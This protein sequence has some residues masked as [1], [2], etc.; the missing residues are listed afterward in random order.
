MPYSSDNG[1]TLVDRA[2]IRFAKQIETAFF[3]YHRVLDLGAGSGTY[4]KRYANSWLPRSKFEWVG[5]EIWKPYI[6]KFSLPLLYDKLIEGDVRE[7]VKQNN[8]LFD[9]CF[10]GDLVEHM[11]KEEGV[12]LVRA[13]TNIAQ[14]VIVSI[15]IVHY[16][17]DA[18]EGNPYEK[19]VKDDWSVEE[20]LSSLPNIVFHGKEGEIG[21]FV[22][23]KDFPAIKSP[24]NISSWQSGLIE[25]VLKPQIGV[26]AI[27]K[28]EKHFL[29]EFYHSIDD[30][31]FIS[32]CD[33]GSTDGTYEELIDLVGHRTR[34]FGHEEE[35]KTYPNLSTDGSMFVTKIHVNPWRFDDARN[36]ALS[37]LPEEIDVCISI[38]LDERL[39][40]GWK[41]QLDEIVA[42]HLRENGRPCDRYNHRF[43][44]IWNWD[45]P[46]EPPSETEHW[47]ERIHSRKGYKWSLPVHE[48]LVNENAKTVEWLPNW[49]MIQKPDTTKSRSSY[50][51]LLEQSVKE[52]PNIWKSWS[53]LAGEYLS[54][55]R[56]DDAIAAIRKAR[57]LP[58]SDK[59]YLWYQETFAERTRDEVKTI[60]AFEQCIR[61]APL[62]REYQYYFA[63]Y[64]FDTHRYEYA[65]S[66]IDS[67]ERI[68]VS[69]NGYE[70]NP[71]AWGKPFEELKHNIKMKAYL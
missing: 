33:T 9:I 26:Y 14:V 57:E 36:A 43:K 34:Q 51:P 1:K 60:Q 68:K 39:T 28:N 56:N 21:V 24:Y 53:F 38:D 58:N 59:A 13:A 8:G 44:T 3:K 62:I 22:C 48:I 16:P 2:I 50:F 20:V 32:I 15:P 61:E 30:A 54:R 63:K 23:A 17:Q 35:H 10:I 45:R 65:A 40:P 27:C 12:E 42:K 31:D 66:V 5:V 7:V 64:L 67:A 52:N 41:H 71:D 25:N 18:Y 29:N 55:G 70:Y 6:E 49:Y 37:F 69:T 47:H 4:A 19:H 11:T 46:E